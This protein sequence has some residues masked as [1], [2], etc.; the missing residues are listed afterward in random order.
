MKI[1]LPEAKSGGVPDGGYKAF[2]TAVEPVPANLEKGYK[3]GLKFIFTISEGE[4]KGMKVSRIVG[5][6]NG[7]KANLPVFLKAIM[8]AEP[9]AGEIDLTPY[10]GKPYMVGVSSGRVESVIA[11]L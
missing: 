7:P 5:I 3:P 11:M 6:A 4:H 9:K 2:Y 1:T 8:K 10:I